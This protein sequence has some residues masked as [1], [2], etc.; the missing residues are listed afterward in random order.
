MPAW[1]L[2]I[3][4]TLDRLL[5]KPLEEE[6]TIAGLQ[7]VRDGKNAE[8]QMGIVM[9]AGPK[10][11]IPKGSKVLFNP[12]SGTLVRVLEKGEYTNYRIMLSDVITAIYE[13]P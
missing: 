11:I 3:N 9:E 12:A 7:I 4:P 1:N 5:V 10:S 2:R 6:E 13:T 8:M